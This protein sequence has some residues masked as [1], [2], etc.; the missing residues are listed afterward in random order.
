MSGIIFLIFLITFIVAVILLKKSHDKNVQDKKNEVILR[1]TQIINKHSKILARKKEQ[2]TTLDE[3]GYKRFNEKKWNIELTHFIY[4]VLLFELDPNTDLTGIDLIY[5]IEQGVKIRTLATR[6]EDQIP[7][8]PDSTGIEYEYFCSKLFSKYGWKSTV[9]QASG[10]QGADLIIHIDK[11]KGVVQCKKYSQNV[12]N[13][14]IQEVYSAKKFY[15]AVFAVVV[16]NSNFT[17]SAKQLAE[18]LNVYLCH[19]DDIGSITKKL[20]EQYTH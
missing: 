7:Y 18:Q 19:H 10:D 6:F 16:T 8:D 2:L 5:L 11:L 4:N 15:G 14:A 9:T 17:Q 1:V 20:F 3:Y 13:G 12:G